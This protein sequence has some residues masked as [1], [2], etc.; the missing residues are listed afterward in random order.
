MLVLLWWFALL[1]YR[2][3]F[4]LRFSDQFSGIRQEE[5]A[6]QL[7]GLCFVPSCARHSLALVCLS[8][9]CVV[10]G[11]HPVLV[12]ACSSNPENKSVHRTATEAQL[13]FFGLPFESTLPYAGKTVCV[14]ER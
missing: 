3:L 6:R 4:A 13:A 8:C 10:N 12:A 5:N 14:R 9:S 11:V 1:V 7:R 2:V